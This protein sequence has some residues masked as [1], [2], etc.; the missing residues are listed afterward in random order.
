MNNTLFIIGLLFTISPSPTRALNVNQ[1]MVDG[2]VYEETS[3]AEKA[4]KNNSKVFIGRGVYSRGL[5]IKSDNVLITGESGTHF[6]NAAINGKAVFVVSGDNVTIEN[7]RCS[8]IEVPSK[9]GACVRQ[10]GKNLVLKNVHF[11]DSQQGILAGDNTG[12]L[13]IEFSVFE[14]LGYAGKAHGV[15]SGNDELFIRHSQIIN[16]VDQG[17]EVKTRAKIT[18]IEYS[19][20]GSIDTN[21]SR[22]IDNSNGGVLIVKHSVIMQGPQTVNGQLMAYGLEGLGR[23]REHRIVLESNI[24]LL[25]RNGINHFLGLPKQ[26]N[27]KIDIRVQENVIIGSQ[28]NS[29]ENYKNFNVFYESRGDAKLIENEVPSIESLPILMI[30]KSL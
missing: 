28:L 25:E 4:I 14:R 5:Y 27:Q 22:S 1:I 10:E 7:V 20:I 17:H 6:K 30:L 19:T 2:I 15:Y 18:K 24:F 13:T 29:V 12:S 16:S 11:H 26:P 21:D 8:E 9:N 3:S 23:Q